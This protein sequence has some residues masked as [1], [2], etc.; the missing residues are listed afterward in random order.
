M[1]VAERHSVYLA[2]IGRLSHTDGA[3][4]RALHRV[5]TIYPR[6][7]GAVAENLGYRTL[8]MANF[9]SRDLWMDSPTHRKNILRARMTHV[10]VGATLKER[11]VYITL[12]LAD[13]K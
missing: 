11:R 8:Q 7:R 4:R 12:V 9:Q 6:Y 13:K 1:K 2:N 5:Q 3:G 10:G